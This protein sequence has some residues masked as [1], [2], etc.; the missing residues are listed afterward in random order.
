[1][2]APLP[3]LFLR[4]RMGRKWAWLAA[5]TNAVLVGFA[6]GGLSLG[7]Y[8]VFVLVLGLVTPEFL[9]GTKPKLE[10]K[11]ESINSGRPLERAAGYTLLCMV[12]LAVALV[13][14]YSA[15]H[16]MN[17]LVEI[18]GQV[19]GWVD[20]LSQ[21]MSLTNIDDVK[22][23]V[24]VELPSALAIFSLVLVWANLTVL[25]RLNPNHIRE[26]LAI[27]PAFFRK[28]KAPEWLVWPTI[29]TGFF[30]LVDLGRASDVSL[31]F[32]KFF[33]AIYAIQGMSILSYLFDVWNIRGFFRSLGFIVVIFL[34]MPLLLS[35]GFFD[36]WFD[37]R[38]KLRQS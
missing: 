11:P 37:F 28:W 2:F 36:L 34:M 15:I 12:L 3:I 25:L 30:L 20:Q 32:F 24:L 19:S 21:P 10:T 13:G 17:P 1:M 26:S 31:N 14:G 16:H 5:V 23:S 4:I 8:L 22:Q 35:L 6:G 29:V 7:C 27:D 9:L 18:K 33:M 38:A